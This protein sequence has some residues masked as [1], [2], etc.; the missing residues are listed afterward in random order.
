MDKQYQ[1]LGHQNEIR[2][3]WEQEKQ[4]MRQT[5]KNRDSTDHDP[6]I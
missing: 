3:L 5:I 6:E 4:R 2:K 1:K